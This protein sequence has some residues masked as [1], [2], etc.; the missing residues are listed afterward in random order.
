VERLIVC[1]EQQVCKTPALLWKFYHEFSRLL[2]FGLHC[3]SC[4]V[5]GKSASAMAEAYLIVEKGGF[6]C[7][8][9]VGQKDL[10]NHVPPALLPALTLFEDCSLAEDIARLPAAQ[11]R[12]ITR[13]LASYCHYHCDSASEHKALEFLHTLLFSEEIGG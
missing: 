12:R 7:E 11:A 10:R 5:C 3:D 6:A 2:G 13:L 8:R 9:C 4:V 1:L